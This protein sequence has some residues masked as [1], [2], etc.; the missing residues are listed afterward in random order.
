MSLLSLTGPDRAK[1]NLTING[2][3]GIYLRVRQVSIEG[4]FEI[5]TSLTPPE[6]ES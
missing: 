4:Y 5:E 3:L 2:T 1:E 6:D